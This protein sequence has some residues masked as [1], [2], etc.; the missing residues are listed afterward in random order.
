LIAMNVMTLLLVVSILGQSPTPARDAP[1]PAAE[2]LAVMK[3]S[4]TIYEFSRDTGPIK[5]QPDPAF[6]LG[7]QANGVLEGAIFLWVDPVGRPEAAAQVFLHK[8]RE[9][10]AGIWLH[11][12]TSLSTGQFVAS[13]RG[14][15]RWSP[16]SPGVDFKPVPGAPKPAT[17]P[18]QRLRQMRTLAEEFKAEDDFGSEGNI[19]ALRLLTTPVARY[20]KAGGTP[21]D[22]GLF[23]FVVGT[24]PE[25][26]LFLEV[27]TGSN[28]PEWQYACAPMSCWPLK[29]THKGQLVWEVP[30]RSSDDPSRPF[31]CR[32]YRPDGGDR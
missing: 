24:D 4:V 30:R 17:T 2:R 21:E 25:V 20:G 32:T 29:V 10:P 5:L 9:N 22:G 13:Q 3:E 26:F 27:R 23:A 1:N 11:E 18:V 19:V 15:P 14:T 6:R 8:S 16:A 28:G 31:F 7:N 12:F